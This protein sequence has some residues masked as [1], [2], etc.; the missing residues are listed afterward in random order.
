MASL[1]VQYSSDDDEDQ[2]SSTAS[3]V[4]P[5]S[6][7]QVESDAFNLSALTSSTAP[8]VL[9]GF[10]KDTI[11]VAPDVLAED[12][13]KQTSLITRPTDKVM[14]VNIPY[15]DMS[16]PV[17]GPQNPWDTRIKGMNSIAGH[18]EE[19]KMDAHAFHSQQRTFAI[20]GYAHN[21]SAINSTAQPIIGNIAS[22]IALDFQ[23]AD[24]HRATKAA[25]KDFKRKRQAKGDL[26]VVDGE[27]AYKGPWATWDGD[28]AVDEEKEE[29]AK[30]WREEKKRREEA[31]SSAKEKRK[32]AGEEKSIFHGKS[33]TDYAG[34]T[35]MHVPTD[36][37]ISLSADAPPVDSFLPKEC[38]HTFTGHTKGVASMKL[39]PGSGHLLLSGSMDSKVKLW[40]VYNDGNCLRTFM[41]HSQAIKDVAFNNDGSRFLTAS[42]DKQMKLWDTETGQCIKAF[43]NGKRPHV[44]TFHPDADKQHIFLAGMQ[45]KKIIQY[46]INSDTITQEY[47]QHLGPV[48]TITFVDE[49]RRF[50]TTSDD[51][52]MRAWDYDIPVVIK[53]IAEPDMH[54]MPAVALHPN[55][56][57]L[58]AQSLD[59]QI[60]VYSTDGFRQNRKKRFAGH[61]IAGYACGV[62]FSPDGRYISSG[63]SEG[64]LV[65]WDWKTGKLM[66]RLRAHKQVVISHLWLPHESSKLITASWDG[67]MKLWD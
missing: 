64:N 38:I 61:T 33:L 26:S 41:G 3:V 13:N 59:N 45:D 40:D 43:S 8:S 31:A 5:L 50:V 34:R 10:K 11:Q 44:V 16:R 7:S 21:P 18:V 23:T 15:S 53:L 62:G 9:P 58:A 27:D 60:L 2:N 55:S 66:K 30:E 63:D 14:N 36:K 19:Q 28:A 39:F 4:K 57:W 17:V 29:E 1:L 24:S 56:K 22:A 32:G 20:H 25:K 12:P 6:D 35:Y 48:N 37:G 51:K 47:D 46:D 42:Y 49:N 52:S 54:S 67:T 65:F